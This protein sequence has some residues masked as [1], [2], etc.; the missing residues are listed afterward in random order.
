MMK[1]KTFTPARG[2]A[3]RHLQTLLPVF[4]KSAGPVV[5]DRHV[6]S[7]PDGDFVDL[8]W[9]N[10]PATG[11][12][13]PVVAMFHGLGGSSQSH[14]TRT[15]MQLVQR[16]NWHAVVMNFRGCSGREN[17]NSRL[18]HSG[19]TG[20]AGFF[21]DWLK[22][23]YPMLPVYAVGFSLGGNMLLKLAGEAGAGLSLNALV[24][25]S[26][27]IKLDESTRYMVSGVS[28]FYQLYLL[29][30]LKKKLLTK[31]K[32]HDYEA[33]I[34]VSRQD[35]KHCKDIREFDNLFT[36]RIHGFKDADDYYS[37]SSAYPY[38]KNIRKPCLILHAADDPIA[39]SSILPDNSE[40]PEH[41]QLE[42]S[43]RG[44]HVGFL[45]GTIVTPEYWLA[46]RILAYLS[47][48]PVND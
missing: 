46:D 32:H 44:G 6:L 12:T 34:G 13:K 29:R 45:G 8:D 28:R 17:N 40:L 18:Y 1:Y 22:Q 5:Y 33:L 43:E 10:K 26:A 41:V 48:Y 37:K 31:F 19:E 27:P 7:L 2:A 38:I 47:E 36:A 20:D 15:L 9:L 24:S 39:P 23:Q 42:I 4:L 21:L 30:S 11:S 35:I 16:K 3:N 25:V 14:Y